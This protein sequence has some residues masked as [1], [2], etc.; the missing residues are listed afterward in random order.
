TGRHRQ[1]KYRPPSPVDR[2]KATAARRADPQRLQPPSLRRRADRSDRD[3]FTRKAY[4]STP[5]RGRKSCATQSP[6]HV[7]ADQGLRG[8]APPSRLREQR[9]TRK[10]LSPLQ[11]ARLPTRSRRLA[12]KANDRCSCKKNGAPP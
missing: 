4:A 7:E 5:A 3:P 10:S 12:P 8:Q 1:T 6:D 9:L 2:R 11:A